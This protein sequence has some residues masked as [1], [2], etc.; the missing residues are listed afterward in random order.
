MTLAEQYKILLYKSFKEAKRF[1]YNHP[2][3]C[4][5]D[6]ESFIFKSYEEITQF[7]YDH[8]FECLPD[9]EPGGYVLTE[10]GRFEDGSIV[11][12]EKVSGY[13]DVMAC[14]VNLYDLDRYYG[15]KSS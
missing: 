9:W 7:T 13:K 15:P 1:V 8:P 14:F 10:V 2:V 4:L 11:V 12:V 6:W 3:K 5:P